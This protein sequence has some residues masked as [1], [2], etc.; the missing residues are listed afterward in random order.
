MQMQQFS[1]TF[2]DIDERDDFVDA[3]FDL[4]GKFLNLEDCKLA[5]KSSAGINLRYK[6]KA[7]F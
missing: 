5:P 7:R 1:L 3:T 6:R 4:D 2:E